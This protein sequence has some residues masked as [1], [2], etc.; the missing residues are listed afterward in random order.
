MSEYFK[1]TS[2][3]TLDAFRGEL[4]KAKIDIGLAEGT[5]HLA[6]PIQCAGHRFANRWAILPMEG[7]DC[8][9]DGTPGEFTRRRWLH[10]AQSGAKLLF[11]TEA[12]AVIH[13]GR[14]NPRQLMIADHT[15][16]ALR[17]LVTQMRA[18]HRNQFG[19]DS[20]ELVIGLQLTHSG[21][22]SHPNEAMKLEP[23]TAYAHV[24]LDEKFHCSP[25]DVVSDGELDDIVEHFIHAAEL[26]QEAGFDFVDIK[27]AHGYLGHEL[28]TSYDRSGRYGGSFENRTR[29]FTS[30]ADGIK[31]NS[32][33]LGIASR[34]SLFDIFPF[35]KG[36]DG[37]GIPMHWPAG[38]PYPYAFGGDGTGKGMDPD[39]K[40]TVQLIELMRKHGAELICATIGSPY[41]NVHMQRPAYYPVSD[42]YQMPEH[43]LYNVSRHLAAA[44]RIKE[45]CPGVRLIAS[46]LT[47]LQ[48]Y[49][50]NAAEYA[51][52][53][54][55]A[56][57]AGIGRMVLSYPEFCADVLAGKTLN[58]CR[59]C[60]TF[61]DCTNAPRAGM[62]SG[63]YPLDPFY[64]EKPEAVRLRE[65]KKA[66]R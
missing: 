62:I 55:I 14:S 43:P 40:E 10:F 53:H 20:G 33:G 60:R 26:A 36:A 59:I 16:P 32:P 56:D 49:L 21:R 37:T 66:L 34:V 23:K 45:L 44:R 6:S 31:A 35:V 28:L 24:L 63:C 46:G 17:E 38:K 2:C 22:F 13:S 19:S 1:V 30:I 15:M 65:C 61:G 50:P 8:M 57:F 18:T 64:K 54:G 41:Y 58:R 52:A 3:K 9:A 5:Q 39:L 7:W 47:C 51:I 29:F 27:H 42:G 4:E 12:A 25:A 48:E 11:G